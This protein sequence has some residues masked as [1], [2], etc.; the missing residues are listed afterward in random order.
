MMQLMQSAPC[1]W[2]FAALMF[3]AVAASGAMAG[4]ARVYFSEHTLSLG[5]PSR[6]AVTKG[7]GSDEQTLFQPPLFSLYSRSITIDSAVGRTFWL[8]VTPG[9]STPL[10]SARLDGGNR[11]DLTSA[12]EFSILYG[13]E[14]S[15]DRRR[16]QLYWRYSVTNNLV[17][18]CDYDGL[19][20]RIVWRDQSGDLA[21]LIAGPAVDPARRLFFVTTSYG[22]ERI[23]A[24]DPTHHP[25]LT[26]PS[27]GPLAIDPR[28]AMLYFGVFV[29]SRR[30]TQ[31]Y[32]ANYDGSAAEP[33]TF[34][35]GASFTGGDVSIDWINH[36]LYWIE[37][38]HDTAP[39][40]IVRA[41]D[42]GG[43][44]ETIYSAALGVIIS[45]LDLE[46]HPDRGDVNCDGAIDFG[47]IDGFVLALIDTA[48]FDEALPLCE[49]EAADA[50]QDG[51]VD[52]DD[53]TAFVG[54]LVS[55]R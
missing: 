31:L 16:R 50:N 51:R 7:D 20:P 15:A 44:P 54:L 6:F 8:H 18:R 23:E 48:A 41:T 45:G 34:T 2:R 35:P 47:D 30:E 49:V 52:F 4:E 53:I 43:L 11:E 12:G 32:R 25:V 26:P 10:L 33:L 36:R 27:R 28:N 19:N 38:G 29:E 21:Q 42:A 3:W 9:E 1:V 37:P 13:V 24:D 22:I 17:G 46:F 39:S 55:A 5:E 14:L 40:R